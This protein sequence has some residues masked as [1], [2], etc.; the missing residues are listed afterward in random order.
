MSTLSDWNSTLPVGVPVPGATGATVAVKV[1]AE[2]NA[3]GL[4][5]G[6]TAV[7]VDACD[8]TCEIPGWNVVLVSGSYVVSPL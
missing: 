5:L 8:T 2:P 3:D 4:A 6:L 7:V 1:T